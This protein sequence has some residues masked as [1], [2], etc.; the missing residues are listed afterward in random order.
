[1]DKFNQFINSITPKKKATASPF[2]N[3]S[4]YPTPTGNSPKVTGVFAPQKPTV[5]PVTSNAGATNPV[6]RKTNTPSTL[7]PAGQQYVNNLSAP[8]KRD[9]NG[10]LINPPGAK[11]DRNTGNPTG[12]VTAP[13][14]P[15][16]TTPPSSPTAPQSPYLKY[17]NSLFDPTQV[18]SASDNSTNA[19]LRLSQ[20]QSRNDKQAL[21]GRVNYE[22][23][24]DKSGGL[25]LGAQQSA[26]MINRRASAESAYGAI[27]EGAAARTAGVYQDN[28]NALLGAGKSIYDIEQDE[29]AKTKPVEVDGVLYQPQADGTYKPVT[30]I[31]QEAD[32]GFT[33]GE[34][35]TRYDSKGNIIAQGNTT[36]PLGGTYE[37]GTNPTIDAYVKGIQSGTYKVSDVP[38]EYQDAVAQA[39]SQASNQP[40]ESSKEVISIIDTL[41]ANPKLD[42]IF[43]PVDQFLGGMLGEAAVA[44]N[45]FNQLKGVL[46]LENRQ[47]LKGQGAISDFEFKVLGQAATALG[48]NLGNEFA[49]EELQKLK[50][51][52]S[53]N[54][55]IPATPTDGDVWKAPDGVEYEFKKGLWTPMGNFNKVGGDTNRATSLE[56]AKARIARN[57]SEGSG[58]YQ[59]LGPVVTSGQYKGER[60]LGKYQ[61]MPGNLAEWSKEAIGRSVTPTE[62][63]NN[64]QLQEAIVSDRLTK[65]FKRYGN[66][67][68]VASV[69]FTGQPLAKGANKK[70]V[71]GTT[72][73]DYVRNFNA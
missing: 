70:D 72:G 1:M 45:Y 31:K 50:D 13:N 57:E 37:P 68:D 47:K 35:Q 46:S 38:E 65:I 53:G 26:N 28:L 23:A 40:S 15:T 3:R 51:K 8:E 17:L 10:L 25:K 73:R 69:W 20:I 48:R 67:S 18:K 52:L 71:F 19:N 49:R 36:S 43:G 55:P 60:A 56:D 32:E 39:M 21:E 4:A 6:V 9:A 30:P 16:P 14:T 63:M 42:R 22:N 64:P 58:G 33:L 29:Y 41:L 66:W 54:A 5:T 24:L 27:E 7:P 61:V 34:G 11:F 59:A 2:T 62:F 12:G 44:K